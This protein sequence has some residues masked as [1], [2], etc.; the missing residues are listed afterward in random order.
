MKRQ[1]PA[2]N[3][4]EEGLIA[5]CLIDGGTLDVAGK[6]VLLGVESDSFFTL[7]N[8]LIWQAIQHLAANAEPIDDFSVAFELNR[9]GQLDLAGG[10]GEINRIVNRVETAS[11]WKR[12]AVEIVNKHTARRAINE[13]NRA[14]ERLARGE[15]IAEVLTDAEKVFADLAGK[16]GG[17]RDT[18]AEKLME[19]AKSYAFDL[20]QPPPRRPPI[21][22]L[23]GHPVC[24]K[25]D[26][27]AFMAPNKS[28]KSSSLAAMIAATFA[29]PGSDC[30]GFEAANPDGEAVVHLMTEESVEDHWD[31]VSRS[32]R[33][34]RIAEPPH[35]FQSY[36]LRR[37]DTSARRDFL[38]A[39]ARSTRPLRLLILDGA[40]DFVEDSNDLAECKWFA[41]QLLALIDE[42]NCAVAVTIH[43]NPSLKP[44]ERDKGMGHLGSIIERKASSILLLKK[45]EKE[46]VGEI[47]TINTKDARKGKT[48]HPPRFIWSEELSMHVRY[49]GP[50]DIVASVQKPNGRPKTFTWQKLTTYF[51]EPM[52]PVGEWTLADRNTLALCAG[53]SEATVRGLAVSYLSE[54]AANFNQESL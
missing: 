54:Q 30:L 20:L 2:S 53:V 15:D 45:E 26:L 16:A 47:I 5:C 52:K 12:Y 14:S 19:Q 9:A 24:K 40:A 51:V 32:L 3:D 39:K 44:T 23:N 21:V 42:L 46:G 41:D 35:W 7:R 37:F 50:T 38:F 6:S 17:K 13:A 49:V 33:R 4:A 29:A 8:S 34:G 25:G 22:T 31:M 11:G 10:Q 18:R 1:P 28:G 27:M 48:S 43:V 36:H